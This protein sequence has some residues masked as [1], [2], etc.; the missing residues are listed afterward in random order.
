MPAS[1]WRQAKLYRNQDE[2]RAPCKMASVRLVKW[3]GRMNKSVG[4]EVRCAAEVRRSFNPDWAGAIRRFQWIGGAKQSSWGL[5]SS[6]LISLVLST[7][8]KP[9]PSNK[10]V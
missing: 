5:P 8:A 1:L 7:V 6:V 9:V 4:E 10:A 3:S 2:D